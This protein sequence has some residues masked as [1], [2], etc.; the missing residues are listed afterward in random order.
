MNQKDVLKAIRARLNY[1]KS[2]NGF[3]ASKVKS[4]GDFASVFSDSAEEINQFGKCKPSEHDELQMLVVETCADLIYMSKILDGSKVD[5]K[6]D[7]GYIKFP[8]SPSFPKD[9]FVGSIPSESFDRLNNALKGISRSMQSLPKRV[10]K[11]SDGTLKNNEHQ[12]LSFNQKMQIKNL[13][14]GDP[15]CTNGL[16]RIIIEFDRP[17]IVNFIEEV[18]LRH[19]PRLLGFMGLLCKYD[20]SKMDAIRKAY[21]DKFINIIDI[22]GESLSRDGR[23]FDM[24]LIMEKYGHK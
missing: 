14:G 24:N 7:I 13:S 3:P 15:A 17:D 12:K 8:E 19:R 22:Q 6:E 10:G 2:V 9:G 1:L 18:G 21:R 11:V 4:V 5:T 16:T 20:I 23:G